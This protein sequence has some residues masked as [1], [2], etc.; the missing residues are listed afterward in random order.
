MP[1]Q[2]V[3]RVVSPHGFVMFVRAAMPTLENYPALAHHPDMQGRLSRAGKPP[4]SDV[5]VLGASSFFYCSGVA[6][7][8]SL[9]RV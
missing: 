2:P 5:R 7:D 4:H 1:P 3:P 8:Q 9:P 6:Y